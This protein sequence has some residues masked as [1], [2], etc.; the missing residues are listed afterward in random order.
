MVLEDNCSC[1]EIATN[2][3][4]QEALVHEPTLF[5]VSHVAENHYDYA[6]QHKAGI[7]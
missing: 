3:K 2:H 5:L 6:H 4:T 7:S 1:F